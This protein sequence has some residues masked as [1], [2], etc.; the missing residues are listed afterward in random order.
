MQKDLNSVFLW[1]RP[2]P[3]LQ[4][5][6]IRIPKAAPLSWAI[7]AHSTLEWSACAQKNMDPSI[8]EVPFPPESM[9]VG[10]VTSDF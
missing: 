9:R 5:V 1:G 2:N 8:G 3:G 4:P 6:L 10:W 7:A